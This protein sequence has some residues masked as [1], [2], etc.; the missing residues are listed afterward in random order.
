ML[1]NNLL[2]PIAL[3]AFGAGI[4]VSDNAVRIQH[5]NGVVCY[6]L[7]E[8]PEAAF[9]L[10]KPRQRLRQLPGSFFDTLLK[11]FIEP[12]PRLVSLFGSGKIDQHVHCPNQP[13]RSIME[14]RRVGHER[15]ARS[16]GPL[17]YRLTTPDRTVLLQS[18]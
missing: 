17:G 6:P 1:A 8:K 4:P 18:P 5:V 9:A 7:D 11:R 3:D 14:R 2:H 12:T 15:H 16:V 10:T 13:T